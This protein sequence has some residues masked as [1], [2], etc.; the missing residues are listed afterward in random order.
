M[1]GWVWLER[2]GF[3]ST[4]PSDQNNGHEFFVA[5][6]GDRI[7]QEENYEA[8]KKATLFPNYLDPVLVTGRQA[9]VH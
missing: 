9:D 1:E 3:V 6:K 5:R 4:K 7:I 2:E 8:Y